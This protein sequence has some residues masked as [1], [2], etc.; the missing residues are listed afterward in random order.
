MAGKLHN[1]FKG[2]GDA[3]DRGNFRGLKLLDHV[4]KILERVIE[5]IIRSQIQIYAM[6][7]GFM[8]SRGT[9]IL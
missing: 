7:F 4:M 5:K 9:L 6:Q 2:K 8:P 1:L 3:L